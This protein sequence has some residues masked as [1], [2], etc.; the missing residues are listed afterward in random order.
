M[1]N[2]EIAFYSFKQFGC[3][4]MH[5]GGNGNSFEVLRLFSMYLKVKSVNPLVPDVH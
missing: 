5:I 3:L 1:K 4:S 2:N